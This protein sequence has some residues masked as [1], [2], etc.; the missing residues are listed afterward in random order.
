MN[1]EILRRFRSVGDNVVIHD[2]AR[3]L[4]PE[5]V[6][7][8]S[9]VIIDDFVFIGVRGRLVIGS[10][11]HIAGFVSVVGHEDIVFQDFSSVSWGSRLFSS[12]DDFR[13]YGLTNPTV[14]PE[15]RNVKHAP[16]NLGRHVILG[17][18]TVVLPGVTIGEGASVGANCVVHRDLSA[19][20]VYAFHPLR[21]IGAR[22]QQLLEKEHAYLASLTNGRP[23]AQPAYESSSA[24]H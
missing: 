23:Y 13:G 8:G 19:W 11:V 5:N 24:A 20:R 16:I 15:F 12:S 7:I 21:E 10:N 1:T 22:S 2:L 17:A 14:P 4:Y 3:I 6:E 18:N 9:N